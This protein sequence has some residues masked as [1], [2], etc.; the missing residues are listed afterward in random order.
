MHS[1][2]R[3]MPMN[4]R[5]CH[6]TRRAH[7]HA[8]ESREPSVAWLPSHPAR[9][10]LSAWPALHILRRRCRSAGAGD[11]CA[12]CSVLPSPSGVLAICLLCAPRWFRPCASV[13]ACPSLGAAGA[14]ERRACVLVPLFLRCDTDPNC[15]SNGTIVRHHDRERTRGDRNRHDTTRRAGRLAMG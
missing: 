6:T 7:K 5:T 1:A 10:V 11:A 15:D 9:G 8:P 12:E 13:V 14:C 3:S 2:P 4:G